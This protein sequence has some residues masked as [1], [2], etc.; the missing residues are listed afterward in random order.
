MLRFTLILALAC[1]GL[2]LPACTSAGGCGGMSVG[3]QGIGFTLPSVDL[4]PNQPSVPGP[5]MNV[6][7]ETVLVPQP[8]GTRTVRYATPRACD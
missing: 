2:L 1:V 7:T 5:R 6:R 8:T 4:V 3:G